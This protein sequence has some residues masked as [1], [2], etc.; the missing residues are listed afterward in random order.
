[1]GVGIHLKALPMT[2]VNRILS[3][4]RTGRHARP[5]ADG[6]FAAGVNPEVDV[7]EET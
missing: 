7:T 1:V 3:T 6:R 5:R 4:T 2:D